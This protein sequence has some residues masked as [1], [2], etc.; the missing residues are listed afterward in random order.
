MESGKFFPWDL[1]PFKHLKFF[2]VKIYFFIRPRRQFRLFGC[3]RNFLAV[4]CM[5]QAGTRLL[6]FPALNNRFF[7]A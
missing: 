2:N 6:L 1:L 5:T 4:L 7:F 3:R